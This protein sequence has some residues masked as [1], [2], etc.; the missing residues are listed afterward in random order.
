[1][2]FQWLWTCR[3]CG[4]TNNSNRNVKPCANCYILESDTNQKR[5]RELYLLGNIKNESVRL[6]PLK[7]P[8]FI[9][10]LSAP[11]V[12]YNVEYKD[13]EIF[14]HFEVDLWDERRIEFYH[15]EAIK[16]DVESRSEASTIIQNTP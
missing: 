14:I 11:E 9:Y 3:S 2:S 6:L 12:Q 5:A 4:T 16:I 10:P 7:I 13:H 15:I 1:M 8:F